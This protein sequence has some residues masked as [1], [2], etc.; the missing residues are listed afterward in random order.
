M[1]IRVFPVFARDLGPYEAQLRA[2]ERDIKYPIDDGRDRFYID[3][4]EHYGEFFAALAP[5]KDPEAAGF[6]LAMDGDRVI[7]TFGGILRV[8]RFG[9][10]EIPSLYLADYKLAREYRGRGVGA[11]IMRACMAMLQYPVIRKSRILYGAAMRGDRGDVMRSARGFN[12]VMHLA[13]PTAELN[14]YFVPPDKLAALDLS[15]APGPPSGVGLDLSPLG[16]DETVSTAG[17]KDLRLESTGQP[18]AL[19]HLPIGPSRVNFGEYLKRCGERLPGESK[20]CFAV[21]PRLEDHVRWLAGQGI[22]RGAR[23][24]IYAMRLPGA[25]G[26]V[27]YVHLA[28]SEI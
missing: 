18:W 26:A 21:D 17:R 28:T 15:H 1:S 23:C 8:A 25:R 7:G 14:V 5:N 22:E 3:H 13:R 11:K 20:A 2:L 12:R 24:T 19:V 9:D 16:T 4:G 10:R 6:I 27:D